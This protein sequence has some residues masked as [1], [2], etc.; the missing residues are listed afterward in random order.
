MREVRVPKSVR[1]NHPGTL[2][3]VCGYAMAVE[4]SICG[5]PK[6]D[7]PCGHDYL[8]AIVIVGASNAV[9][10]CA[11]QA[12]IDDALAAERIAEGEDWSGTEE[13]PEVVAAF[14]IESV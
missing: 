6:S 7:H 12:T 8:P 2:K 14:G 11:G 13:E 5:L 4:G 3:E 1:A 10:Q 9:V